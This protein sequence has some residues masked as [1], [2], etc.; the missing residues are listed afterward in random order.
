MR[1]SCSYWV[2]ESAASGG[3]PRALEPE[4]AEPAP[5]RFEPVIELLR[6]FDDDCGREVCPRVLYP[7]A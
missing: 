1:A 3:A 7:R 6:R 5:L 2:T 4:T